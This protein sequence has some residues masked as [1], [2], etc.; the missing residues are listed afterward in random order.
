MSD[1]AFGIWTQPCLFHEFSLTVSHSL[2]AF[3]HKVQKYSMPFSPS[4][5]MSASLPLALLFDN[6][7]SFLIQL[8]LLHVASS[9]FMC[10]SRFSAL[11]SAPGATCACTDFYPSIFPLTHSHAY[12]PGST[13]QDAQGMTTGLGIPGLA[14]ICMGKCYLGQ[15][16]GY[17][18]SILI[19]PCKRL[20]V[21][22]KV[23]Y[24]LSSY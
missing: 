22:L 20:S 10:L 13:K 24:I 6:S 21:T 19:N 3:S 8:K 1:K 16:T 15:D 7:N 14:H 5:Q 11:L 2:S 18:I 17:T 4:T 12:F 23:T 9:G